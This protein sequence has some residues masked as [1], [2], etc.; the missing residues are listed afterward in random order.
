MRGSVAFERLRC[1]RGYPARNETFV[2]ILLNDAVYPVPGC[3]DGPGNSCL[4]STYAKSVK[5]KL[6]K[7]GNLRERCNV[8]ST[9]GGNGTSGDGASF[10]EDLSLSWLASVAP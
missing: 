7:A 3:K 5:G 2:R 8:T 10:F 6:E 9:A 1:T 4:L